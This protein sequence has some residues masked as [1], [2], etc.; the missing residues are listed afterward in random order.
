MTRLRLLVIVAF[1]LTAGFVVSAIGSLHAQPQSPAAL[2]GKVSSAT[3]GPMEGVLVTARRAGATMTTTVV[4]DAAGVYRFPASYVGPGNYTLQIRASGYVLPSPAHVVVPQGTSAHADL[5]LTATNDLEDQLSNGEWLASMPGTT[6]QK[7]M[8]LDCTGCHTLQRIVDSYHTADDFKNNVLPRMRSYANNTFWLKPQAFTVVRA[9]E[10]YG[11]P[12]ELAPYL[13]SVNQ[14][15]GTRTWPLKTLP[16]LTGASTRVVITTYDLPQRVDQPHD[17]VGTPDGKIWYSDFGSEYLGSLDPKTGKVTQYPYPQFKPGYIGGA[18]ELDADPDGYL[19]LAN[20]FQGGIQ[21]FDP[22]TKTFTQ[23]AVPP[24]ANPDYTQESMVMPLH[25]S[26]DGKVWTNNQDDGSWKRLDVKTGTWESFGPYTYPDSKTH[27]FGAYG[28][29][30]DKANNL[31]GLDF[32][33]GAIGHLD[34]ATK[35]FKIISTPTP[36][37]RPRRGRI[38]DRTGLFWFA[39]WANNSIGVYDTKNDDGVIKEYPMPTPFDAPYDA[40]ADKNGTV[41]TASMITDHVAHLDPAT[42]RVVEY[43]LPL[44]TNTR[45]VWVDDKTNPVTFWTGANHQAAIV[46]V[47][48]LQ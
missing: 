24:A 13:A 20:M 46:R 22:K 19:W 11:Y 48:P 33:G 28:I 3:E 26:V 45:R 15:A 35:T 31:W 6:A 2:T 27:R 18:L 21:R 39:E 16:R 38:D 12:A 32:G 42:G 29:L 7:T 47:E 1:A 43:L 30:S 14:S 40:V 4:S 8:L 41:W 37:S 44:E 9:R 25:D 17:V 5:R 23:F 34:P 36:N 10:G